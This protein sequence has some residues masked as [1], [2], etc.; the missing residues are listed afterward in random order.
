MFW[1]DWGWLNNPFCK[2][3]PDGL[4]SFG[5]LK[6]A[7]AA[8]NFCF[9]AGK[10]FRFSSG[11][12][13][14]KL[15]FLNLG[16]F[17]LG[18]IVG[19]SCV[20]PGLFSSLLLIVF[21]L[22]RLLNGLP[23]LGGPCLSDWEWNT[24]TSVGFRLSGGGLAILFWIFVFASTWGSTA[25]NRTGSDNIAFKSAGLILGPSFSSIRS[26]ACVCL[27]FS[28][29]HIWQQHLT[30]LESIKKLRTKLWNKLGLSCAKLI[31]YLG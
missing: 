6:P 4:T 17:C 27:K 13:H 30:E 29:S 25:C 22:W 12:L 31:S 1:I 16:W 3:L 28:T 9:C 21:P 10:I 2:G 7:N 5:P 26:W 15:K 23:S 20:L 19:L 18:K 14:K 11:L 24:G 8:P